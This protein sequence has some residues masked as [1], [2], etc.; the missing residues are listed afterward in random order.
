MTFVKVTRQSDGDNLLAFCY[1][2]YT[3]TC[4]FTCTHLYSALLM[5]F[6]CCMTSNMRKNPIIGDLTNIDQGENIFGVILSTIQVWITSFLQS[7]VLVEWWKQ[8]ATETNH[9]LSRGVTRRSPFSLPTHQRLG[10]VPGQIPELIKKPLPHLPTL[11]VDGTPI[12]PLSMPL[13]VH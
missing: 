12:C 6:L 8:R 1:V 10:L 5:S 7:L 3:C 9:Y 11:I 13:P 2:C 4:T